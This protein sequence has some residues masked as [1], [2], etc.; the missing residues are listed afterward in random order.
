MS[1]GS[2]EK[3][4]EIIDEFEEIARETLDRIISIIENDSSIVDLNDSNRELITEAEISRLIKEDIELSNPVDLNKSI[5]LIN[6]EAFEKSPITNN[7][8]TIRLRSN[9]NIIH[10][11]YIPV[12]WTVKIKKMA[13]PKITTL[14]VTEALKIIPQYS[15]LAETTYPFI[16]ACVTIIDAV[17]PD[18]LPLLLKMIAATKLTGK[19]YN[20][21]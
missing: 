4:A 8:C 17:E 19:A 5:R 21:T 2:A 6:L 12:K 14:K 16:S 3:N 1:T 11:E 20:A 9:K 13:S 10:S 15:G 7:T 18:Q